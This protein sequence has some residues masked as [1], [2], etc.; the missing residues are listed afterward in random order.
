MLFGN[1]EICQKLQENKIV[2]KY[3]S[4]LMTGIVL[5]Y[6]TKFEISYSKFKY[7]YITLEI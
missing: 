2:N 6:Q 1:K 5:D 7:G 4:N 3:K